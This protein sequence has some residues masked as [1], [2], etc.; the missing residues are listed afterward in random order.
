MSCSKSSVATHFDL[1]RGS[2][3]PHALL[4]APAL[5]VALAQAVRVGAETDPAERAEDAAFHS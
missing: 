4:L 5:E 2:G 1:A 3:L